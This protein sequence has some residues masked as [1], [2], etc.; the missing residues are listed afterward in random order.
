[1]LGRHVLARKRRVGPGETQKPART[2]KTQKPAMATKTQ[3]R[4]RA[5]QT[6]NSGK[7]RK[8]LGAITKTQKPSMATKTQNRARATKT[9][10]LARATKTQSHHLEPCKGYK[11][12]AR[13]TK[14]QRPR[15]KQQPQQ[16]HC[17]LF[18][19]VSLGGRDSSHT[20]ACPD[21]KT[22]VIIT[23]N[24]KPRNPVRELCP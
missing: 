21:I 14:T 6:Q 5:T 15:A 11:D 20:V 17:A 2:T 19:D 1:M 9:Q 16:P 13:V 7:G 4:A 23:K 22:A 24:S 18:H 3:N 10:K 12:P 8:D